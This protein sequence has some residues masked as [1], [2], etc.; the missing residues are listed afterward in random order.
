MEGAANNPQ[1]KQSKQA[2]DNE[3]LNTDIESNKTYVKHFLCNKF[4]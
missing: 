2:S 3:K 1:D 4:P